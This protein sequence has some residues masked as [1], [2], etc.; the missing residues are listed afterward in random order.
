MY[1]HGP[2]VWPW[3][4]FTYVYDRRALLYR[5]TQ[6]HTWCL[7]YD[8]EGLKKQIKEILQ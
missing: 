4:Y 1:T 2:A 7:N 5:E 3:V 6:T 8:E